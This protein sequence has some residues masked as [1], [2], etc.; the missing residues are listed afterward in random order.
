MQNPLSVLLEKAQAIR[1]QKTVVPWL[2]AMFGID[3][4]TETTADVVRQ[5]IAAIVKKE[6]IKGLGPTYDSL[7]DT[8]PKTADHI[9]EKTKYAAG[10]GMHSSLSGAR[11]SL[12]GLLISRR[13][14][15]LAD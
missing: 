13:R 2:I 3:Y 7:V 11:L 6:N 14:A 8:Y 5:M 15:R 4:V 12:A 1:I 9:A 10:A